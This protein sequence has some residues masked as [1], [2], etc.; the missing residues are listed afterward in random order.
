MR[1]ILLALFPMLIFAPTTPAAPPAEERELVDKVNKSIN[2]GVQFLRVS[3]RNG[4]DWE[5]YWQYQMA[6][7]EGGVTALAT[8]ALLNC[9]EKPDS[10]EVS[11]ALDTLRTL[12]PQATYVVALM[13]MAFA[14]ARQARDLPLIQRQVDW[15]LKAAI[16]KGGKIVGWS[17]WMPGGDNGG[18]GASGDASNTQYA[19]LGLYAGKQAGAK[20]PDADWEDLFQLYIKRQIP[21]DD[22]TGAWTYTPDFTAHPSFT[23]T[24]AGVSGLVISSLGR[25]K[26]AQQL[27][28]LTGV[29]ANCGRY[30]EDEAMAR[31][32]NFIGKNFTFERPRNGQ[33]TFYN[34]YGIE[35]VG[36][37]SGR[38][39]LG[40]ID[41]YREGCEYLVKEQ[42]KN[43]GWSQ[44]GN[45]AE[46][47][48][49]SAVIATSFSLLFL[50]KGRTPVL[51]SK[52]AWGDLKT[53]GRGSFA[54]SGPEPGVVGWDRKHHDLRHLTEY[55]SRELFK[56]Q[57]M[58]WQVYDPRRRELTNREEINQEVGVL[59]QSPVLFISG[60]TAPRLTGQ[61]E[62]LLK[63][64]IEEG[65]FVFAEA[66]CGSPEFTQGFRD[67]VRKLF[68]ETPLHPLPPEHAIWQSYFAVPP[69]TFPKLEGLS[70]GC[71]TVMV[72]SGDPLS[73]YWDEAKYQPKPGKADTDRAG[74]AYRLGANVIAYAT[75]LEPPQ[76][77]LTVRK[78]AD[79]KTD[80]TPPNGFLKPAQL[81][82][83]G[84]PAPA[85]AAMRN[86]MAHVRVA[87]KLDV[88]L[89][90]ELVTADN[91]ELFKFK[92]LYLHGRKRFTF[93]PAEE[94]GL[95]A[96]LQSGGLLLADAACGSPAFD[97]AFREQIVKALPGTKLVPIPLDDPL[98]SKE[99]S[100]SAITTVKR[101]EKAGGAAGDAGFQD[102]PP[103]LEGIKIDGR[104]A[105][106]YS[107]YDLGCSLE[108]HRSTD[109][110]GHTRESALQL[111]TAA[112]V[113]MLKR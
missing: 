61:Q 93:T 14:E 34:I 47:Y 3:M 44:S 77:R 113:Y 76:Q 79:D 111:A 88:V 53:D 30:P 38:R 90:P 1:F 2:Q 96:T 62:E 37:L 102:L 86:L 48:D 20:I 104:W 103:L 56:G 13:A 106:I 21:Q 24:T 43:G 60:H 94:E 22:G 70:R 33:S 45:G 80:R 108:G 32:L 72:L 101:R 87:A 50:S 100:G 67:L 31:G 98:Y 91:P 52:L 18:F 69:T 99:F 81:K 40:S 27:A 42:R 5:G 74:E 12:Q 92:F 85:P 7:M 25:E 66:C 59:V 54:E 15:L 4:K 110:L 73:G 109:C 57:P 55:A 78:I 97:A 6:K 107:K 71:R 11:G 84:D 28:P 105:V 89:A 16:R 82:L 19:L 51:M 17:Y 10:R 35:R 64:Y 75:G 63:K 49:S 46:D 68:P 65:G 41:W 39:F 9:G 112:V 8:L 23:M 83:A 26:S 36:R 58:G 29:A 95:R